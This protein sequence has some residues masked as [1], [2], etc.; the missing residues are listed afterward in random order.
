MQQCMAVSFSEV[1][2]N[3]LKLTAM[4]TTPTRAEGR[5]PF[6]MILLLLLRT[7]LRQMGDIRRRKKS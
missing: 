4:V 7:Y 3:F 2:S 5:L 1:T 6:D